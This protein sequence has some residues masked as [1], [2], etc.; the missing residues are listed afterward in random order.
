M[1]TLLDYTEDPDNF[2]PLRLIVT[3]TAGSGKSYLIKCLVKTIRTL[4]KTNNSVQVLCPTGNSANLIDGQT[5]HSFFKLPGFNKHKDMRPPEGAAGDSLQENCAELKVLLVDERSMVG[6]STLGW[7]EFLCRHGVIRGQGTGKTWGGLPV[8][9]FFGDD[10]QLPPV[11]DSPVYKS[12]SKHPSAIHGVL[13]WSQFNHAVALNTI[14]RQNEDEQQLRNALMSLRNYTVT[15]EQAEWMQNFQWG[16]LEN[17]YGSQL[18]SRISEKGLFVFPTH[19]EEWQHNKLKLLK[20][21]EL[22]PIAK[23]NAE[24]YG[25]HNKSNRSDRAC[26][27][28]TLFICKNAKV[29]LSVNLCVQY[30]LF[31][32]AMGTIKDILFGAGKGPS[33]ALPEVI[34]VE[35][36]GYTGPP[37]LSE[38]KKIVPITP[39]ERRIDCTCH[40][41]K[42]KQIPLRLGWATTIHKCQGMTIGEGET[43]RYIV[44][45][46]GK[47]SF[48]TSNPGA[49][50]VALSR[51]KTAG[52]ADKDPDFAWHPSVLV[53]EDRL[54]HVVRTPT[55]LARKKEIDRISKLASSTKTHY[56]NLLNSSTLQTFIENIFLSSEE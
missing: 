45:N 28:R 23:I 40:Y 54:C 14:Q 1:K 20:A 11:L 37:F 36:P 34:L 25:P 55:A 46:P 15:S 19:A 30:G 9:V 50:F 10:A 17:Q 2:T 31:N 47:P 33:N 7:V 51:A 43:N 39:V 26:L 16:N 27:L 44:I 12:S 48:E 52:G 13:I 53:N 4:F 56:Q 24:C 35:F 42:R 41:C 38:N 5:L 49:L 22:Y 8:V 29:M 18:T 3:G 21:N 32:G 6:A